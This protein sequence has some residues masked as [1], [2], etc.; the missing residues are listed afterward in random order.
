MGLGDR[1]KGLGEGARGNA[2]VI[3]GKLTRNKALEG[4][5]HADK[6]KGATTQAKANAEE[7]G[8]DIAEKIDNAVRRKTS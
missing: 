6:A 4:V 7:R 8:E 3:A 5:G 1:A 2:E